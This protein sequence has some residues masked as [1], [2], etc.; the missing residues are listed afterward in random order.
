[1]KRII[2]LTLVII[3]CGNSF[4]Q[5][6]IYDSTRVYDTVTDAETFYYFSTPKP[7]INPVPWSGAWIGAMVQQYVPTDTMTVYGVA[8]PLRHL[9]GYPV[10]D[11]ISDYQALLMTRGPSSRTTT[12]HIFYSMY[13]V[14]SVTVNR[15]HPRFCWFRYQDSCDKTK[16]LDV[17]CYEFYFDTPGQVNQVMDTFYVGRYATSY[18]GSPVP[19]NHFSPQE[20]GGEYASSLP[21]TL[22]YNGMGYEDVWYD[23]FVQLDANY[24]NK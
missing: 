15:S 18:Y 17:P 4:A 13:V 16:I 10:Y 2:L 22:Y 6:P 14:D 8:I 24:N 21:N 1:M 5:T 19:E 9:A 11:N 3:A 23:Y 7:C 12:N 20:Y